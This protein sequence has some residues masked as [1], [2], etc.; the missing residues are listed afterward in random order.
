M[1]VAETLREA[2]TGEPILTVHDVTRGF[3]RGSGEIHVL[4]DV[5]LVL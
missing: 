5:D 4:A 1:A 2:T 3:P